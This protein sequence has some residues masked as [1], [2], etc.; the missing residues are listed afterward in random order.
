MCE[1]HF[2]R[3]RDQVCVRCPLQGIDPRIVLPGSI[4]SSNPKEGRRMIR[5]GVDI[6]GVIEFL[7]V[8]TAIDRHAMEAVI[9]ARVP[10][11]K[12]LAD[13][14][15]VQVG[16]PGEVLDV[17]GQPVPDGEFRVGFLGIL[18]GLFGK[19]ESG[20]MMAWGPI[21]SVTAPRPE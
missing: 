13:N 4:R 16:L 17:G 3:L 11:N 10:C 15:T 18:N 9:S 21:S 12:E 7:N 5:D 2:L 20:P 1:P 8:L 14:P 19:F 6:D